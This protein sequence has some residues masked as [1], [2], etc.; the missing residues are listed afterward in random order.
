MTIAQI[1]WIAGT[2]LL[3]IGSLA[4]GACMRSSQ[5]SEALRQAKRRNAR[6]RAAMSY[7]SIMEA[8]RDE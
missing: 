3:F 5:L 7:E 4:I 2:I 8:L 1:L 6:L